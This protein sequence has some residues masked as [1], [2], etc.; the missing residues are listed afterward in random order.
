MP[1][2]GD[3]G[4]GRGAGVRKPPGKEP[5][6]RSFVAGRSMAI[7]ASRTGVPLDDKKVESKDRQCWWAWGMGCGEHQPRWRV[8]IRARSQ[9]A[10]ATWARPVATGPGPV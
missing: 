5:A 10:Q 1:A 4:T 3:V 6:G 7:S 2:N 8:A 9:R